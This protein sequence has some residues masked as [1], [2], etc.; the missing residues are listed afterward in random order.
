LSQ[1]W[2]RIQVSGGAKVAQW[3]PKYLEGGSCP[4]C[5]LLSAPMIKIIFY[6]L[7]FMPIVPARGATRILLKGGLENGNFL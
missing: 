4:H 3:G 1:K 5:P 2:L 6:T 7:M